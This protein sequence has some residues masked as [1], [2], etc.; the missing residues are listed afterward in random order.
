MDRSYRAYLIGI[1][2]RTFNRVELVCDDDDAAKEQARQLVRNCRVELWKG[3]RMIAGF[4][5]GH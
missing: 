5:P 1:D 3:A 4:D 2:C